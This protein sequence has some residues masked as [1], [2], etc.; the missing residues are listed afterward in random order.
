MDDNS[1]LDEIESCSFQSIKKQVDECLSNVQEHLGKVISLFKALQ[2][3]DPELKLLFQAAVRVLSKSLRSSTKLVAKNLLS[4]IES[5]SLS[6]QADRQ[7]HMSTILTLYE[8]VLGPHR[9]FV[10]D[11]D[12]VVIVTNSILHVFRSTKS[13]PKRICDLFTRL[14]RHKHV[15]G[16]NSVVSQL[17]LGEFHKETLVL[18]KQAGSLP[19]LEYLA[20]HLQETDSNPSRSYLLDELVSNYVSTGLYRPSRSALR[21]GFPIQFEKY[22]SGLVEGGK[23]DMF[24][25]KLT[26][27]RKL[28]TDLSRQ[29]G[30]TLRARLDHKFFESSTKDKSNY[31]LLLLLISRVSFRLK[32]NHKDP[33]RALTFG[34]IV[35]G[36]IQAEDITG[37]KDSTVDWASVDTTLKM[38][39]TRYS[40]ESFKDGAT[41]YWLGKSIYEI[42]KN[43]LTDHPNSMNEELVEKLAQVRRVSS[44]NLELLSARFPIVNR[45]CHSSR[46]SKHV[47]SDLD[48]FLILTQDAA[49]KISIESSMDHFELSKGELLPSRAVQ[50]HVSEPN[51]HLILTHSSRPGEVLVTELRFTSGW[52]SRPHLRPICIK[53]NQ[54]RL[55]WRDWGDGDQCHALL[56]V[57][58]AQNLFCLQQQV[59]PLNRTTILT[60]VKV[61]TL[62]Q[63]LVVHVT[64]PPTEDD[65]LAVSWTQLSSGASS[66]KVVLTFHWMSKMLPELQIRFLPGQ[67]GLALKFVDFSAETYLIH[68][69]GLVILACCPWVCVVLLQRNSHSEFRY[70]ML[71]TETG[72]VCPTVGIEATQLVSC[73]FR[74]VAGTVS[75]MIPLPTISDAETTRVLCV[76]KFGDMVVILQ[77]RTNLSQITGLQLILAQKP[78]FLSG[79]GLKSSGSGEHADVLLQGQKGRMGGWLA[80][81]R[82][83]PD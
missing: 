82:I 75:K 29:W 17:L 80:R 73:G 58:P 47:I 18:S 4:L 22:A 66:K 31:S 74:Q 71:G 15:F 55:E 13:S 62:K 32:W 37:S 76:P 41:G 60:F 36:F 72:W 1:W 23:L 57:L 48:D 6:S 27:N 20:G 77:I 78:T 81:L 63:F 28:A 79:W 50:N 43:R 51:E 68:P 45:V 33:S 8:S 16:D 30:L 44:P 61:K 2:T 49:S 42:R 3:P 67:K 26:N 12:G 70:R 46:G 39:L 40:G 64:D 14:L 10:L 11:I 34:S 56:H 19:M 5:K 9:Q 59:F 24:L 35:V 53:T 83:T 65:N 7:T 52:V 54:A 69:E 38:M 21:S 25:S